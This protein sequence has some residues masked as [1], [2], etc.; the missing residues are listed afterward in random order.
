MDKKKWHL[1]VPLTLITNEALY[2]I[3]FGYSYFLFFVIFFAHFFVSFFNTNTFD[4][5]P[6]NSMLIIDLLKEI[7]CPFYC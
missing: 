3:F 2:L 4:T 1:N 5:S 7:C 6:L